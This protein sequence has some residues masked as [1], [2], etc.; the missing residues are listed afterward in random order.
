MRSTCSSTSSIR[1]SGAVREATIHK[2]RSRLT[3]GGCAGE[4]TEVT[5]DGRSTRSVAVESEDA[6]AVVEAVRALGL[7][8]YVNTSYPR[9]LVELIDDVPPRYAVLDMGTN[10]VKFHVGSA[11]PTDRG[12]RSSIAP[13]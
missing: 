6:D 12:A 10:S 1:P 7:E 4:R 3:I 11:V 2:R 9:G 13:R 8:G 5:V